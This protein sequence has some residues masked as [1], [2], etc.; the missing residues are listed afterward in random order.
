MKHKLLLTLTLVAVLL[1]LTDVA[2]AQGN[3]FGAKRSCCGAR[4]YVDKD[5]DGIC[6]NFRDTNNDGQCD[7]C[8]CPRGNGKC[9]GNYVDANNDGKCDNC[10]CPNAPCGN[11]GKCF[12]RKAQGSGR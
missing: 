6:D 11:R 1:A 5:G 10:P 8:P 9:C 7:N 12:G 4:C 2:I 3:G